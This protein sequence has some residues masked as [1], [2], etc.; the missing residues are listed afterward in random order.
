MRHRIWADGYGVVGWWL[1]TRT[2]CIVGLLDTLCVFNE[3]W[4]V[5]EGDFSRSIVCA[6]RELC[7]L[8]AC[9]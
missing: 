2:L 3:R 7:N 1:G 9:G 4:S 6:V 8:N 5:S